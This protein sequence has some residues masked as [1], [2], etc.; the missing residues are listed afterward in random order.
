M[1]SA[2]SMVVPL[3]TTPW[4]LMFASVGSLLTGVVNE[5]V[6]LFSCA[7]APSVTARFA[8]G[9]GRVELIGVRLR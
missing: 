5:I 7:L 9:P 3:C 2:G 8:I 6:I 1:V 4:Q